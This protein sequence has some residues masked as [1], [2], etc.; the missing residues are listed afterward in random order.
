MPSEVLAQL[1]TSLAPGAVLPVQL[2][3]AVRSV[4]VVALVMV[5]ACVADVR[6]NSA[7]RMPVETME[8]PETAAPAWIGFCM[9]SEWR[10]LASKGLGATWRREKQRQFWPFGKHNLSVSP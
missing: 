5:V 1:A 8:R 9:G 7:A 3:P 2:A 6:A 10:V 4:P